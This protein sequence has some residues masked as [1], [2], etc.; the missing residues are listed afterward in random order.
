M[1]RLR[2]RIA[3]VEQTD[4]RTQLWVQD[5]TGDPGTATLCRPVGDD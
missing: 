4:S 1:S 2:S 3:R 5:T